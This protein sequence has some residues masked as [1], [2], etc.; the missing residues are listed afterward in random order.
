MRQNESI[1]KWLNAIDQSAN[2]DD[3][4]PV[5]RHSRSRKRVYPM[6]PEP[7][8]DDPCSSIKMSGLSTPSSKR[9]RLQDEDP[10]KTPRAPPLYG[11]PR[12]S[13]TKS[14]PTKSSPSKSSASFQSGSHASSARQ[15]L[16]Q[17]DSGQE[18]I[19]KHQFPGPRDPR[20]P[21]P[22]RDVL[23]FLQRLERGRGILSSTL[24]TPAPETT[25]FLHE[26][27]LEQD[28]FADPATPVSRLTS[29]DTTE[30]FLDAKRCFE[31]DHDEAVWNV[32]VHHS[33]LKKVFRNPI[34]VPS[35]TRLVD[36]S[37][38][39]TAPIIREYLPSHLSDRRIDFCLYV[40]PVADPP[41]RSKVNSLREELP[42]KSINHS[43]YAPLQPHPTTVSIETKRSGNDFDGGILQ[44]AVWQAAHWKMLR[45]LL[46]KMVR[47]GSLAVAT[48]DEAHALEEEHVNGALEELGALHGIFIQ[49]HQWY[50]VATS[51]EL[52]DEERD[53]SLR[54]DLWLYKPIGWT[55][56]ALGIHKIAAFL[57]AMFSTRVEA[58]DDEAPTNGAIHGC[59]E[60][61][62]AHHHTWST[63]RP[64]VHDEVLTALD[65][66]GSIHRARRQLS[67]GHVLQASCHVNLCPPREFEPGLVCPT[68]SAAPGLSPTR[69]LRM[70]EVS[71]GTCAGVQGGPMALPPLC[72]SS[73]SEHGNIDGLLTFHCLYLEGI[74]SPRRTCRREGRRMDDCASSSIKSNAHLYQ[75]EIA[76]KL[77]EDRQ[78]YPALVVH[79]GV[80]GQWMNVAWGWLPVLPG[81]D[82][83]G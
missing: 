55:G 49:G 46:R 63:L 47:E 70:P 2:H 20:L 75:K 51:P 82:C 33:L 24:N 21:Q 60:A 38:C 43:S 45:S 10:N 66:S 5:T 74:L 57:D 64:A 58:K 53:I 26:F 15:K 73:S 11:N 36:F 19:L 40:D 30:I 59:R 32:E 65:S 78:W 72:W 29:D 31:K 61:V 12:L 77:E 76:K 4:S 83:S 13:P 17:L 56:D 14:S 44:M 28:V 18:G 68:R 34:S 3:S 35:S 62:T 81:Q 6:S 50:Y 39:T 41:Y 80:I 69:G 52:T 23:L 27:A 48:P 8:T 71:N 16:S 42:E 7:D 9:R 1:Y 25:A 67:T 54:T 37:L 22:I 79:D